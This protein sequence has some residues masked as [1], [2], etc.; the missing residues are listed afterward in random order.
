MGKTAKIVDFFL[1]FESFNITSDDIHNRMAVLGNL[2]LKRLEFYISLK[3][4]FKSAI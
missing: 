1:F 4:V 3:F 2:V